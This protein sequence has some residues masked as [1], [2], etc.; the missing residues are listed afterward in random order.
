VKKTIIGIGVWL[1]AAA[2]VVLP[3]ISAALAAPAPDFS[4]EDAVGGSFVSLNSYKGKQP[5]LILFWTTWCPF[6]Q[7]ALKTLNQRYPE[8]KEK[9]IEVL[10]INVGE[11]SAKAAGA[12]RQHDLQFPVLLD[13]T[14]N[15]VR[16]YDLLGVPTYVLVDKNGEVVSKTNA[17][18]E[19]KLNDFLNAP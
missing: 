10:A 9:D 6:C 4:L 17:F 11:S 19:K 13:E 7:R 3:R 16:S 2:L 5:V 1:C 18:P 12:A 15:T 14:Q 8:L